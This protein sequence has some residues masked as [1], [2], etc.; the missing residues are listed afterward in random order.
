MQQQDCVFTDTVIKTILFFTLG[1]LQLLNVSAVDFNIL[2]ILLL[3]FLMNFLIPFWICGG[4]SE[5]S[6]VNQD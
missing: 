4:F 1:K 3:V 2:Q 6:W 5:P